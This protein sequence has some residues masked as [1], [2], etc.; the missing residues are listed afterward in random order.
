[1]ASTLL[2]CLTPK[3][4]KKKNV[5]YPEFTIDQTLAAIENLS[6]LVEEHRDQEQAET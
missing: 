4:A 3:P 2:R 5:S 1:M 6:E